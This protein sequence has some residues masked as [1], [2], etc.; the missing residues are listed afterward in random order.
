V[1]GDA[2]CPNCEAPGP[3]GEPCREPLCMRKGYH[4]VPVE[5]YRSTRD[6]CRKKQRGMDPLVGRWLDRYLL[7]G[8][9]GQGGMGAVYLALQ[10]PLM[11]EVACKLISGV[12]MSQQAVARFEREARAVAALEHPNIVKLYD[13]GVGDLSEP[14]SEGNVP[15]RVPYMALEYVR[16]GRTLRRAFSDLARE[17]GSVP[18]DL[19]LHV[20]S[21]VL[22]ALAAAHRL[23]IVHRDMKP[24]N[25]L[26]TAVEGDANFVKLL[27]FGLAKAVAHVTGLDG[28]VSHTGQFL[29]TPQYVA[30]EQVSR[31]RYSRAWCPT[32]GRPR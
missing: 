10:K 25:V 20:F 23:G 2:I 22:N 15:F 13:Y 16:H 5:W 32:M 4:H 8:L 3:L 1:K 12:E 31:Q 17:A 19:V 21:Q 27:D 26:V 24:D 7:A 9:I 28:E 14:E 11:R 29:G 6:W 18:G 30:P